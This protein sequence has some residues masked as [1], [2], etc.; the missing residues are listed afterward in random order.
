MHCI[1]KKY[2]PHWMFVNVLQFLVYVKACNLQLQIKK[3]QSIIKGNNLRSFAN[4][5]FMAA[6]ALVR[7]AYLV[8]E[9]LFFD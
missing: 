6:I 3:Y 7:F 8:N 4:C 9:N 1:T 2:F 5:L